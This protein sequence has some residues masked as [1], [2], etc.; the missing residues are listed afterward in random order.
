MSTG[1]QGVPDAQG[2]VGDGQAQVDKELHHH[3]DAAADDAKAAVGDAGKLGNGR[4]GG[5]DGRHKGNDQHHNPG[6]RT[7]QQGRIEPVLGRCLG[8]GGPGAHHQC[9]RFHALSQRHGG[10]DAVGD[11]GHGIVGDKGR[12]Q[13]IHNGANPAPVVHHKGCTVDEEVQDAGGHTGQHGQPV[14][15]SVNDRVKLCAVGHLIEPCEHGL[16]GRQGRVLHLGADLGPGHG[17]TLKLGIGFI[18][19]REEGVFH[20]VCRD[21]A[22]LRIGFD[23]ALRH[24][25]VALNGTGDA[26]SV[27]QDGV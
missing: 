27:L 2:D 8:K 26:G 20:H 4:T 25:H 24:A 7:G 17:H 1:S 3:I 22:L 15:G 5:V 19:H 9:R 11:E 10:V 18:C 13:A 16:K 23:G 6:D 21:E 14:D 12:H